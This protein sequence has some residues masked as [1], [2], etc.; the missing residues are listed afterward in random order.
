ML[1]NERQRIADF[2]IVKENISAYKVKNRE[3][4]IIISRFKEILDNFK[5][6]AAQKKDFIYGLS[7][8]DN[9]KIYFAASS[10]LSNDLVI[11]YKKGLLFNN[12]CPIEALSPLLKDDFFEK[13]LLRMD[14]YKNSDIFNQIFTESLKDEILKV[15]KKISDFKQLEQIEEGFELSKLKEATN[16]IKK[17]R[18]VHS[19]NFS[20]N[21]FSKHKRSP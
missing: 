19:D 21:S 16:K 15:D 18:Y 20:I 6:I 10:E 5:E 1:E 3:Y 14:N 8:G 11:A 7:L 13:M 9:K 4:D 17:D 2:F 12:E